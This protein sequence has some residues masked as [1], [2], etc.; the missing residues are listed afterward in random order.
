[1]IREKIVNQVP[2][3]EVTR[4]ARLREGSCSHRQGLSYLISFLVKSTLCTLYYEFGSLL[5]S[6]VQRGVVACQD[7]VR[8]YYNRTRDF[9]SK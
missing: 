8:K 4:N 9:T 3:R 2:Y 1:M 6:C 7:R 5:S